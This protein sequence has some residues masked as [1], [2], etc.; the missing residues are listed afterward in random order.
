MKQMA[1]ALV[2]WII[3]S[4][5]IWILG[6]RLLRAIWGGGLIWV[7]WAIKG[8]F[9][10]LWSEIRPCIDHGKISYPRLNIPAPGAFTEIAPCPW[11]I[12]LSRFVGACGIRA[13]S[14]FGLISKIF[15]KIEPS[16]FS[17]ESLF[18]KSAAK[19]GGMVRFVQDDKSGC[20][21]L[22]TPSICK[23][24]ILRW[25][26]ISSILLSIGSGFGP[27]NII[28]ASSRSDVREY[29]C[30]SSFAAMPPLFSSSTRAMQASAFVQAGAGYRHTPHQSLRCN[31]SVEDD[32]PTVRP[33]GTALN[34]RSP[35]TC[36]PAEPRISAT[37]FATRT[38]S[39]TTELIITT[40]V[41]AN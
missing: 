29:I 40:L 20:I 25:L 2:G 8:L 38:Q 10:Q 33:S 9:S 18:A 26:S 11:L 15:C 31:P 5:L 6:W 3:G 36:Q 19:G 34:V 14:R 13:A 32:M 17:R 24:K 4:V 41:P 37:W 7:F 12:R 22:F 28:A 27:M 1:R 23:P 21:S 16:A 39:P 30:F 35:E